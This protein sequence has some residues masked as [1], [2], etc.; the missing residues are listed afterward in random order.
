MA[1]GVI[2]FLAILG[3][4]VCAAI[5]AVYRRDIRRERERV[6]GGGRMIQTACGPIEYAVVGD[7]PAVLVVHGAGGGFDQG[8]D[9]GEAL[10]ARGFRVIAMSRFGYL[11]TPL[12]ADASAVA[13]A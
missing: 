6:A 11:R 3:A 1:T 9:L 5:A 7:G 2:V 8:L 10:V 13:Q 12:P 4:V